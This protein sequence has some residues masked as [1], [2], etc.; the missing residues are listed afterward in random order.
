MKTLEERICFSFF[1]SLGPYK[2]PKLRK[3]QKKR[4]V[5]KILPRFLQSCYADL[6]AQALK[7]TYSPSSPHIYCEQGYI[8]QE[9]NASYAGSNPFNN[10]GETQ[11]VN[12]Y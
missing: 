3:L 6:L 11:E 8:T 4:I 5:N 9:C 7:E 2:R 10:F 12:V 1:A